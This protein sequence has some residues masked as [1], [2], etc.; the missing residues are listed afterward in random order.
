MTKFYEANHIQ[1]A[2]LMMGTSRMGFFNHTNLIPYAPSPIYNMAMAGASIHEQTRYLEYMITHHKLKTIV[3]GIDFFAF[4]PDKE[5]ESSFSSERLNQTIYTHDY[6]DA[7]FQ[8]KTFERSLKTLKQNV[9]TD[10][11]QQLIR[12][13]FEEAQYLPHQG[14]ITDRH[15]IEQNVCRTLAEYKSSTVFLKSEKFKNPQS[16]TEGLMQF[17]NIVQLCKKHHIQCIFYISPVYREHL[18]MIYT[19]GLGES[20]EYWKKSLVDI[21]PYYDFCNYNSVTNGIMNFRDSAHIS[22]TYAPMIFGKIFQNPLVEAPDDFGVLVTKK[23]IDTL[24]SV[25]R[26]HSYPPLLCI[27]GVAK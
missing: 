13:Y 7:L 15:T 12:P 3:W 17:K 20:F 9:H 14:L 16:L 2:T 22:S 4:N 1:P 11:S 8:Y 5:D 21:Q 10:Y 24:L 26:M 18:D 23:N 27:Q 19:M 6:I 25:Q